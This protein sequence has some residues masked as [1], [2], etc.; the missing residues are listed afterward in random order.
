MAVLL[1]GAWSV[2]AQT[3]TLSSSNPAINDGIIVQGASK[4]I[5]YRAVVQVT[6]GGGANFNNLTFTPTGTFVASD[7]N[8][9]NT[10]FGYRVWAG[11]T[12][13]IAAATQISNIFPPQPTGNQVSIT[14]NSPYWTSGNT[15]Y[16]WITAD[17]SSTAVT[18]HTLTV[19][20]LS[21]SN[22]TV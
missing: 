7:I 8:T 4:Q 21:S 3:F 17:I 11:T 10:N 16:I 13:N 15:Y 2:K 22:F 14:I 18:G 19:G 1:I 6:G 12:D 20:A 9:T 5:I